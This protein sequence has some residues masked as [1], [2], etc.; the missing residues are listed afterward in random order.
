M[1]DE[2]FK[3]PRSSY[4]ELIK[5]IQAYGNIDSP[6]TL[7]EIDQLAGVGTTNVSAN[8]AFLLNVE[9]IEGKKSKAITQKGKKLALALE[10][11]IIDEIGNAWNV[12][13][14]DNNFLTKMI[15]AVSI[16]N[17]MEISQLMN[18]IAYSAGEVNSPKVLTGARAVVD[19]LIK[20][21]LL[22]D[23]GDIILPNDSIE[24]S[25]KS[26]EDV[27]T[28]IIPSTHQRIEAKRD[29]LLH[30][31]NLIIEIKINVEPEDFDGLGEKN[32]KLVNE[33]SNGQSNNIQ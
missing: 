8:N 26:T 27:S 31:V 1:S 18:H 6:S 16:R 7:V 9:I 19:I 10:H 23:E 12:I 11:N 3:L 14:N 33:I 13:I 30:G 5:I 2:K 24:K 22:R 17:G 15:K 4:E 25:T 32:K 21:K 28:Q 20:S 29:Q